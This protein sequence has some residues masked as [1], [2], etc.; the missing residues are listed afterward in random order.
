MKYKARLLSVWNAR[1][2]VCSFMKSIQIL[3]EAL[4]ST[5]FYG[6]LLRWDVFCREKKKRMRGAM[7]LAC[8]FLFRV[9][10]FNGHFGLA[11]SVGL[12]N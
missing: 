12:G 7:R 2:R 8:L 11:G 4:G 10:S 9:P 3:C 5:E 1:V 6:V